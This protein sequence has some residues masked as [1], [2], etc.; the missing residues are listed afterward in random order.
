MGFLQR[1]NENR[2][3][4]DSNT[5]PGWHTVTLPITHSAALTKLRHIFWAVVTLQAIFSRARSD[6]VSRVPVAE[7]TIPQR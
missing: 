5:F 4:A 7:L 2:I 3:S 6:T 1:A